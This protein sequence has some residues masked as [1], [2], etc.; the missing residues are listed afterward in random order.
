MGSV[1]NLRL[2]LDVHST[3]PAITSKSQLQFKMTKYEFE[4]VMNCSSCDVDKC[5]KAIVD[6]LSKEKDN[7]R[8]DD[9]EVKLDNKMVCVASCKLSQDEVTELVKKSCCGK[10]LRFVGPCSHVKKSCS[11]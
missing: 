11:H 9:F 10:E 3:L 1:C 4:V 5:T 2:H 8:I 6:M 7:G